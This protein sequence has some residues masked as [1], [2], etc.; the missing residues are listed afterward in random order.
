[1]ARGE[2][3]PK[4]VARNERKSPEVEKLLRQFLSTDGPKGVTDEY[5]ARHEFSFKWTDE[6]R[7]K[8]NR[9]LEEGIPFIVA[10]N[11][12]LNDKL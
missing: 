8:V 7:A 12:V 11:E 3:D 2:E 5:R 1:M 9:R 6:Q 4:I 10:F